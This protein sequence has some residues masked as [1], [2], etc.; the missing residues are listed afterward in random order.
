MG[1]GWARSRGRGQGWGWGGAAVRSPVAHYLKNYSA[2]VAAVVVE[3]VAVEAG[4]P[5]EEDQSC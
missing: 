1:A 2:E 5:V 3:R 4:Q